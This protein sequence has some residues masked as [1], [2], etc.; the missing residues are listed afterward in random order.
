MLATTLT[1]VMLFA[2]RA[3]HKPL[4][5]L[6][7]TLFSIFQRFQKGRSPRPWTPNEDSRLLR[8]HAEEKT[9]RQMQ[10]GAP[11]HATVLPSSRLRSSATDSAKLTVLI[12]QSSFLPAASKHFPG[13]TLGAV[14]S[15]WTLRAGPEARTLTRTN[16]SKRY[17][18][19]GLKGIVEM[20]KAGASSLSIANRFAR[21]QAA[22]Q[23]A[24]AQKLPP[25]IKS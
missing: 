25:D 19:S 4:P 7:L 13:Q 16:Q 22:I 11:G 5:T 1:G 21:S 20:H 6:F 12:G 10:D 3:A 24:L 2:W 15:H 17:T 18:Q 8:L 23:R 9:M 14:A